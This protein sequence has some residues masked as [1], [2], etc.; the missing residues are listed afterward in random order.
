MH[1]VHI[2]TFKNVKDQFH[3][4][5]FTILI[6]KQSEEKIQC[7]CKYIQ[8]CR[9]AASQEKKKKLQTRHLCAAIVNIDSSLLKLSAI[10]FYR[11]KNKKFEK[12]SHIF[13]PGTTPVKAICFSWNRRKNSEAVK[14]TAGAEKTTGASSTDS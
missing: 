13:S 11:I 3:N 9:P 5:H 6:S 7:T 14:K 4:F 10:M 8:V 1:S 12:W 2:L